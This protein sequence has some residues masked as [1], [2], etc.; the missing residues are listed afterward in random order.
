MYVHDQPVISI[1]GMHIIVI[2]IKSPNYLDILKKDAYIFL[3]F[4]QFDFA[5][6]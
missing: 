2:R 4:E 1:Y 6:Q 3:N 5:I